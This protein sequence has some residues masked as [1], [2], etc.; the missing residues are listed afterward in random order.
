[1]KRFRDVGHYSLKE[2][3]QARGSGNG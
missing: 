2:D 3:L 1:V